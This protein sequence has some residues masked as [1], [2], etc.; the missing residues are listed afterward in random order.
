M[1]ALNGDWYTWMHTLR[2]SSGS[3]DGIGI[4]ALIGLGVVFFVTILVIWFLASRIQRC[5]PNRVLVVWGSAG[6]TGRRCY[7]G[8]IK[9][10][11][12][13]IQQHAYMSTEP[14]VIDIPLGAR[15]R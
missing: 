15:C 5:P 14:L 9:V 11:F 8:G 6:K 10:V 13:V 12:P 4:F 7:N 1:S 2:A 3:G